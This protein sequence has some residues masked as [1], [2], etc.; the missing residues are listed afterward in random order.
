MSE[1]FKTTLRVRWNEVDQQGVV[2]NGNYLTY[3]D[4]AGT[5]YY[6]HLGILG[7]GVE[8]LTQLFVVD[9][10]LSFKAPALND[11]LLTLT[12]FPGRVGSSSFQLVIAISRDDT[13]LCEITLTYVRAL[14]GRS[15]PLTPAFR[16][17]ITA[18]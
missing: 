18:D 5:E 1:P 7:S 3:A 14:G 11:D 9:A 15:A 17:L 8:D 6:R 10:H 2:F 13:D 16:N 12:V 4:V